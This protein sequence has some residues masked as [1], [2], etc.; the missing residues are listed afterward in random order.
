VI[1]G[2]MGEEDEWVLNIVGMKNPRR[3]GRGFEK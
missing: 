1:I 3:L 2:G